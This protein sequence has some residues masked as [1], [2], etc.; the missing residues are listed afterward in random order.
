MAW[1]VNMVPWENS[2]QDTLRV[3]GDGTLAAQLTTEAREVY[4]AVSDVDA[5][6]EQA[7]V[8]PG[9]P[10][11]GTIK[12]GTTLVFASRISAQAKEGTARVFVVTVDYESV[13]VDPF[14]PEAAEE[15]WAT[16]TVEEPVDQD[17]TGTLICNAADEVFDPPVV[18]AFDDWVMTRSRNILTLN[19]AVWSPFL[20]AVNW[21][22]PYRGF[23][24]KTARVVSLQFQRRTHGNFAF[25]RMTYVVAFRSRVRKGQNGNLQELGWTD[26]KGNLGFR[27]KVN[28]PSGGGY[29]YETILDAKRLP[30]TTPVPLSADGFSVVEKTAFNVREFKN[31]PTADLNQLDTLTG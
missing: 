17:I 31:N 15:S 14:Q 28:K 5:T 30:L 2:T 3:E 8:A 4:M 11:R 19:T 9:I 26:Y 7:K 18:R 10:T 13:P 23:P 29:T 1:T 21:D 12:A 25:W 16:Q 27:K 24:A 20:Q 6:A 22:A